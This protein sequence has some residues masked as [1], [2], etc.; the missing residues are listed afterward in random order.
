MTEQ[1]VNFERME[2]AL[3]LFGNSDE[4]IRMLE[5]GYG[6]SVVFRGTDIK[7]SGDAEKVMTCTRCI[8]GLLKMVESGEELSAQN[9]RYM[10]SLVEEGRE[11]EAEA[12]GKDVI[13]ITAKGKPLKPKTLGQ[14]K[15]V[16][17]IRKNTITMG[18]GPAGTG[19]TYL[20]VAMAVKAFRAQ[21]VN[22]IVSD[23]IEQ[24]YEAFRIDFRDNL[25]LRMG[26]CMHMVPLLARI[27]SGMRMK[28][29]ILQDIKRE[30]PLA[31]EMATQACSVLQDVS[32]NPIKEDEI[33]YIA[34]S[35]ALALERQK[36]KEWAPKNILI[37]C[38]SGKG[39]AQLLAYR[40]QQKFGKNLGRVQ[41]CDVIGLRS[42][43]FS[44]IDYVFSTVPIPI[45]VPVPIRQI[46]FFP[47]E[48]ELTQM[49]KLLMQGKKGT[50]EEYFSP[51]LFLPHLNCE[52]R[53]QVLEQM[54]RFVCGK[55]KLPG[56]FLQL[57]KKRE[58]LAATSFGGLVAM[59]HPWK[60]V[61]KDTF[62]CLAIL[63]KPVQ[64]GEAKVQV[65]FQVSIADDA[66]AKLQKFYQVVAQLMVDEA[67]ICKLIA[68]RRFE[69][70]L[71]LLRQKEQGL[72][73]QE[74][75]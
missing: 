6:V 11:Q 40:Y 55:K 42:V 29:P 30:Y 28:N 72:E 74:N 69:V 5:Q 15:Y 27:K 20:A 3:T 9:I 12:L 51:E 46:Q 8:E 25:E 39:S 71:E 70:L 33:G 26:L 49:K 10:M 41:T 14:Q 31:Y 44:K 60:A 43:N 4:N 53:E 38:A 67:C 32:P 18:I 34:V 23:M 2:Y 7:V 73:E 56:D 17:A 66:T 64:W 50:V 61:S 35:F 63:D 54:C 13:C 59:P 45:Y 65:V 48:K 68:E 16:E 22:R 21:E 58:S 57:V 62:V 36:A 47:T 24:I 75:G 52:T 1:I 37:V 19:K